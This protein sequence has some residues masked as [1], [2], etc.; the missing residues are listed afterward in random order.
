MSEQTV[1]AQPFILTSMIAGITATNLHHLYAW[2]Q[3]DAVREM[4]SR[5]TKL[6]LGTDV[7]TLLDNPV[8]LRIDADEANPEMFP[9]GPRTSPQDDL[10]FPVDDTIP[11]DDPSAVWLLQQVP[12][13]EAV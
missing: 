9:T 12:P 5:P 1:P 2:L 7:A 10:T 6:A 8:T 11:V 3:G 4:R 13:G